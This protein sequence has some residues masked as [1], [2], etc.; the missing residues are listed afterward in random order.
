MK[1]LTELLKNEMA[2]TDGKLI[3]QEQ[4]ERVLKTIDISE[5]E[6][7]LFIKNTLKKNIESIDLFKIVL[8]GKG[9]SRD[10]VNEF[11]DLTLN[12]ELVSKPH[13]VV[14]DTMCY[15]KIKILDITGDRKNIVRDYLLSKKFSED[16]INGVLNI[17]FEDVLTPEM[18][19]IVCSHFGLNTGF[20]SGYIVSDNKELYEALNYTSDEYYN[21]EFKQIICLKCLFPKDKCKCRYRR[22]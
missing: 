12:V 10:D 13:T 21:E 2:N 11:I 22:N 20:F 6:T 16:A 15:Q 4:V 7:I 9:F 14:F 17:K 18:R 3:Y 5:A 19:T 8:L 1:V